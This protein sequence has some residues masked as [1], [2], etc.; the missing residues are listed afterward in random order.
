[1]SDDELLARL[2]AADPAS[3]RDAPQPDLDRLLEIP[4]TTTTQRRRRLFPA[5]AAGLLIATGGLIWGITTANDQPPAATPAVKLTVGSGA[6]GKCRAPEVADLQRL[7]IAF[8]GKVT[9]VTGDLISLQVAHWYRGGPAGNVEVQAMPEDVA[10]LLAVDFQVGETYLVSAAN[11]Q[12]TI[13]GL[14][15]PAT[16]DL[17]HLYEQA[18]T[19]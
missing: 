13:C 17:R 19:S 3:R 11:N 18:Y 4:M 14:S 1:M 16:P 9:A 15:G 12:V 6:E 8:E 2:K 5:V 7:P 10:T